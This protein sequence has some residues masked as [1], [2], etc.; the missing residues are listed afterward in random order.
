MFSTA[1]LCPSLTEPHIE[2][3]YTTG[4]GYHY[5][6][7]NT[8]FQFSELSPESRPVRTPSTP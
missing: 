8:R 5:P 7:P 3:S 4:G 1:F 6:V 2:S